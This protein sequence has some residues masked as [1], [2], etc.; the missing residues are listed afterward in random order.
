MK[1]KKNGFVNRNLYLAIP[2]VLVGILIGSIFN[3]EKRTRENEVRFQQALEQVSLIHALHSSIADLARWQFSYTNSESGKERYLAKRKIRDL[4]EQIV[5]HKSDLQKTDAKKFSVYIGEI[6]NLLDKSGRLMQDTIYAKENR[7]LLQFRSSNDIINYKGN[8]LQNQLIVAVNKESSKR[9]TDFISQL[10]TEISLT[11]IVTILMVFNIF[12]RKKTEKELQK[13]RNY[14][15]NVINSMPSML[16]GIEPDGTIMECNRESEIASGVPS[17]YAKGRNIGELFPVVTPYLEEIS[18]KI[19]KREI[20]EKRHVKYA[21]DREKIVDIIA[22]PL[23]MNGIQGAVIR[24]DNVTKQVKMEEQ[25]RQ[26]QKMTAI[27]QLAGGIAHDF[28]NMLSGILGAADLVRDHIDEEG[29]EYVKIISDSSLRA[30]DL[31][32]QMLS[33]ARKTNLTLVP[34]D[35]H[36][37]ILAAI[38][39]LKHSISKT[40]EIKCNLNAESSIIMGDTSQ[41]QNVFLNMGINSAH[42]IERKG[43]ISFS[44]RLIKLDEEYCECS[45]FNLV[46]GEYLQVSV[47]D[48]GCGIAPENLNRIFEPFFTT[49]GESKGTGIGLSTVFGIVQQLKGS[50]TV[51]SELNRGTVFNIV[52]PITTEGKRITTTIEVVRTNLSGKILIIDDEA[53]IRKTANAIL[54]RAGYEVLSASNGKEGLELF[55]EHKN[56]INLVILDMIMPVMN[57]HECFDEIRKI[58]PSMPIILAS[59]FSREEDFNKLQEKGLSGFILKPFRRNEILNLIEKTLHPLS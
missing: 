38:N 35:L 15:H 9:L 20:V 24:L 45:M 26:S 40:I 23:V 42:A 52:L 12:K 16:I 53:V 13:T 4:E 18:E 41:L 1:D 55:K 14:L 50:I 57:G 27:G 11:I 29:E 37:A 46:P 44:T 54:T 47:R 32:K 3:L 5:L 56:S 33:F 2:L 17:A 36:K 51:Y 8:L 43:E 39:L 59:G 28:N 49:K 58:S 7:D 21:A 25:L 31:S 30:A 10:I 34:V 6:N 19:F 22:F 48:N